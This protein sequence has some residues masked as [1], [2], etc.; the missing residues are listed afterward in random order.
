MNTVANFLRDEDG[1]TGIEFGMFGVLTAA[2]VGLV[3]WWGGD[4]TT[5]DLTNLGECL[6][7]GFDRSCYGE[8][9]GGVLSPADDPAFWPS[10]R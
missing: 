2:V 3:A 4:V 1:S 7:F 5:W 6:E 10:G 9:P 8:T